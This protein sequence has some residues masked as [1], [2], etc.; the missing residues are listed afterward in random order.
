MKARTLTKAAALVYCAVLILV[1]NTQHVFRA[2]ITD[3]VL[4]LALFDGCPLVNRLLY[5]HFHAN[6]LH[7]LLNMW[8]FLSCV[9]FVRVRAGHIALAFLIASATPPLYTGATPII[10]LSG[11]CYA[12]LG[13]ISRYAVNKKQYHFSVLLTILCPALL[14]WLGVIGG[15]ANGVHLW[16][17]TTAAAI[18]SISVLLKKRRDNTQ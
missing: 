18:S 5:H 7:L 8:C 9:L 3:D 10:G 17:Y 4:R 14:S 1:F 16:S 2:V 6:L 13:I 11:V 15:L 12:L